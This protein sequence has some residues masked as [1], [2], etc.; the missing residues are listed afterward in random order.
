MYE[1]GSEGVGEDHT[2]SFLCSV[3]DVVS[4]YTSAR[5]GESELEAVYRAA[6]AFPPTTCPQPP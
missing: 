1:E 3:T 6:D 4:L 5:T 2:L